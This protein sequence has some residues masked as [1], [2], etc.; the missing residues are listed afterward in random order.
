V[1][2]QEH[3]QAF[4][5]AGFGVVVLTSDSPSTQDAFIESWNIQ[6]PML[7]DVNATSV[8]ALQIL[9]TDYEPGDGAYGIP[10]PGVFVIG[11]DQKIAGKIF[12]D[13]YQTRMKTLNLLKYA[14]SVL[15]E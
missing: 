3:L 11:T 2:L 10:Y 9:N 12:I 4:Q 13:G 5:D 14:K 6:Y 15:P 7:S 8:K 1:Q